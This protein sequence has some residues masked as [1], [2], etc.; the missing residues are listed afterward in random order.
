MGTS[1]GSWIFAN[2]IRPLGKTTLVFFNAEREAAKIR[3]FRE[4]GWFVAQQRTRVKSRARLQ[5]RATNHYRRNQGDAQ[6]TG[7]VLVTNMIAA[8]VKGVRPTHPCLH[9]RTPRTRIAGA[10]QRSADSGRPPL[11]TCTNR[12]GS[13][14]QRRVVTLNRRTSAI[15]A[16]FGARAR[17]TSRQGGPHVKEDPTS[18]RTPH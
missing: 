18:R 5:S 6:T 10:P 15:R 11:P 14:V 8:H 16:C 9:S 12:G 1:S 4:R 17:R 2:E 13:T 7:T 3:S